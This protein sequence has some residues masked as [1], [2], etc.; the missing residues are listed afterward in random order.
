MP[1]LQKLRL[2]VLPF[3]CPDLRYLPCPELAASTEK[4]CSWDLW[5]RAHTLGW[6]PAEPLGWI[7]PGSGGISSV[8]IKHLQCC[9]RSCRGRWPWPRPHTDP[10]LA[11]S[12]ADPCG[13]TPLFYPGALLMLSALRSLLLTLKAS[14][15]LAR[16][17]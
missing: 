2:S 3:A 14:V 13:R 7:F 4:A 1:F 9:S 17:L 16:L 8:G 6:F 15:A 12:A 11:H 10:S 5:Q